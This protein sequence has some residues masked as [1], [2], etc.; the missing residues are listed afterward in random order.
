MRSLIVIPA[1]NEEENIGK[2]IDRVKQYDIDYLVVN[3]CSTDSTG[4]ILDKKG[5]EHLDLPINLGIAGV[6]RLGFN[7][8]HDNDYDCVVCIDGDGQHLPEYVK[9]L[10]KEIENGCDYV[11]G[12]RFLTEKKPWSMRMLGSRLLCFLIFLK[13]RRKVTDPTSGMRALGRKVIDEFDKSMNFYAEPDALCHLLRQG[14]NVKEIQVR[15]KERDGGVSYFANPFKSI[16]YM[17]C[18]ILSIIFI[19]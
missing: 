16:Y 9:D 1:Y 2:V 17:L 14:Y 11:V 12:S 6:T 19:Q 4:A 15:M 10:M 3:D 5:I 8:A 7:Y 13:T 18:E